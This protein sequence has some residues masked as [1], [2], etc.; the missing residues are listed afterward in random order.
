MVFRLLKTKLIFWK[1]REE[2]GKLS[3]FEELRRYPPKITLEF[4]EGRAAST[5]KVGVSFSGIAAN[6]LLKDSIRL[7]P[8]DSKQNGN[9]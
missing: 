9:P 8:R 5:C 1:Y 2:I 6:E 4:I 7:L 3:Q